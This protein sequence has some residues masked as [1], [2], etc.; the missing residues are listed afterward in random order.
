MNIKLVDLNLQYQNIKNEI[1]AA[2]HRVL[3][4]GQFVLGPDVAALEKEAAKYLNVNYAVGVA[5]GTDALH[6]ALLAYGIGSGDEVITTPFTF[7]ATCEAI[8][9]CGAVPVFVDIDPKTFNI[10]PAK[11]EEKISKKTKAII[12][13]HM[14]GQAADMEPILEIA[15]KF[16][17]K[18]IEDVA[19]AFGG[20]YKNK[21]LGA[22]GNAGCTSFFPSKNLGAFGDGGMVFTNDEKVAEKVKML[23]VHGSK[24][25]YSH[26]LIGF[27][28]R[29]DTLQAAIVRVKLKYLDQWNNMRI[30]HAE[31]RYNK[32]LSNCN[33]VTPYREP[34]N[35]HVYH[36]YTILVND[37]EGYRKFLNNRGIS[38]AIHYPIPAHLQKSF[39]YLG[40]SE[41]DFPVS[42]E[43]SQ[44][45]LSLPMFPEL[46]EKEIDYVVKTVKEFH[47]RSGTSTTH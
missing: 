41:E 18:V 17:L 13:V 34:G 1:D 4:S 31:Q 7:I 3:D 44:K 45:T 11:I 35:K 33:V 39:R 14:Y 32:L 47:E 6:L 26:D 40:F 10:N 19:Q 15:K 9:Y 5:S 36:L 38:S 24:E 28:S 29:L 43:T 46:K 8:T 2:V 27:N 16:Q 20:E 22:L 25:K 12:P 30:E 21:K 23:R 42:S 37:R